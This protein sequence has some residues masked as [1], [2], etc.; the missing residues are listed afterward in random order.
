MSGYSLIPFLLER[1]VAYFNVYTKPG[2]IVWSHM[3]LEETK[4]D[5]FVVAATIWFALC[6]R[7][8]TFKT[9][10]LLLPFEFEGAGGHE[11]W[12]TSKH[13]FNKS[14]KMIP[15]YHMVNKSTHR[16]NLSKSM[17]GKNM[18][19]P[20]YMIMLWWNIKLK[21]VVIIYQLC[22]WFCFFMFLGEFFNYQIT[23]SLLLHF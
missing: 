11:S 22:F 4:L 23:S 15:E 5:F 16:K 14:W 6:F 2:V 13:S 12:Y 17:S 20:V 10:N 21:N 7:P 1:V 9:P 8:N 19:I 3:K 18:G